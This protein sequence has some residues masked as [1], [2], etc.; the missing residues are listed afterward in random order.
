MT[1]FGRD[2]LYSR[3]EAE[4]PTDLGCGLD[5]CRS[6]RYRPINGVIYAELGVRYERIEGLNASVEAAGLEFSVLPRSALFLAGKASYI[7]AVLPDFFIGA[8]PPWSSCLC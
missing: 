2:L 7:A 6:D 1:W 8:Q 3:G 4:R 5:R